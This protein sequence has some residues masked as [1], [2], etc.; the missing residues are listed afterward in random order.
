MVA[1]L[2]KRI[3]LAIMGVVMLELLDPFCSL[4]VRENVCI[5]YKSLL[6]L[7]NKIYR[8]NKISIPH[9]CAGSLLN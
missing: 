7:N 3:Y 9:D 5:G 2:L 8:Y 4:C 1:T 6:Y